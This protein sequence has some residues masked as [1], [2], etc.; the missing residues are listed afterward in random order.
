MKIMAMERAVDGTGEA[1]ATLLQKEAAAVWK[2]HI[3]GAIRQA[4]FTTDTHNAVLELECASV[5]EAEGVL[6]ELPLV[7][8]GAIRFELLPLRPYDGFRRLFASS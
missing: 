8:A 5:E 3:S 1:P 7:A 2:L 4:W 6:A